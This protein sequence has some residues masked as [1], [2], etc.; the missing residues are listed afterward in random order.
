[1][2]AYVETVESPAEPLAFAVDERGALILLKFTEGEYERTISR[3]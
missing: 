3:T 2:K 1:M